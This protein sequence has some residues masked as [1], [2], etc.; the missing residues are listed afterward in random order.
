MVDVRGI[1][2]ASSELKTEEGSPIL[3]AGLEIREK[4]EGYLKS[5]HGSEFLFCMERMMPQ[6]RSGGALFYVQMLL[7]EV[8]KDLPG[9]GR[10][11]MPFPIQLRSYLIKR[12]G[13]QPRTKTD[14]VNGYLKLT[15]S[16]ARVSSHVA[17]AYFLAHLGLDVVAGKYELN[18]PKKEMKLTSWV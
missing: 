2:V 9:L 4:F 7:L 10:T 17:E 12:W 8:M 14:V 6:A 15:Q 11:V 1:V 3:E 16:R 13:I 5:F 18:L